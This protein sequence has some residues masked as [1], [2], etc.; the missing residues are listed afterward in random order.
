MSG[1]VNKNTLLFA[2]IAR[3]L[4]GTKKRKHINNIGLITGDTWLEYAVDNLQTISLRG[5]S[6]EIGQPPERANR[7]G[8]VHYQVGERAQK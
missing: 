3:H 6:V 1:L 2:R 5:A 4:I 7:M 8:V